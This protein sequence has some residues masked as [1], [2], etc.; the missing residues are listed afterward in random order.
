[1]QAEHEGDGLLPGPMGASPSEDPALY[2]A[3]SPLPNA[4]AV[5]AP[6]LLV[7][8][9]KDGQIL[10]SN[11]TAMADSLRAYSRP[12]D[13]LL[14]ESEGHQIDVESNRSELLSRAR[15]TLAACR[16]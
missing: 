3:A 1:M 5:A 6:M 2:A 13:L 12:F 4:Q 11:A 16:L 15:V 9:M 8:G 14:F 7:A 10:P